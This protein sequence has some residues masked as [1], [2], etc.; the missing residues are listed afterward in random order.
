MSRILFAGWCQA[1]IVSNKEGT[2]HGPPAELSYAVP[3]IIYLHRH[4][5]IS[6]VSLR[7]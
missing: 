7:T 6:V 2:Y 3:G 5:E 4:T 1:K